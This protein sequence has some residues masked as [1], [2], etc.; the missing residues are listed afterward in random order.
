MRKDAKAQYVYALDFVIAAILDCDS[1]SEEMRE[2]VDKLCEVNGTPV[3]KTESDSLDPE[4]ISIRE[5]AFEQAAAAWLTVQGY[6][7]DNHLWDDDDKSPWNLQQ[8]SI[9]RGLGI[10]DRMWCITPHTTD[11]GET[12][13]Y[14]VIERRC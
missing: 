6:H 8:I 14:H 13:I 3:A 11:K 9:W 5:F 10:E 1:V 2:A 4:V 12:W 7:F